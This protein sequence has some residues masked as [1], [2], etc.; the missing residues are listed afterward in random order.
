MHVAKADAGHAEQQCHPHRVDAYKQ[1]ARDKQQRG[2]VDQPA[3]EQQHHD[4]VNQQIVQ[5]ADDVAPDQRIGKHRV[6]DSHAIEQVLAADE[7]RAAFGGNGG[8]HQ[9]DHHAG[10]K[11]RQVLCR[12]LLP[13]ADANSAHYRDKQAEADGSPERPDDGAA[14]AA[15]DFQ[16]TEACPQVAAFEAVEQV[17]GSGGHKRPEFCGLHSF[18]REL[19]GFGGFVD[20]PQSGIAPISVEGETVKPATGER[21]CA[22]G[23]QSHHQPR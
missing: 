15:L 13:E 11:E 18:I 22:E 16:E 6:I 7:Q 23:T 14:I 19:S 9:P 2:K 1:Q 10:G 12:I 20:E 21:Q 17:G 5:E 3:G 8:D 4:Q